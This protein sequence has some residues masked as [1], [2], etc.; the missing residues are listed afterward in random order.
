MLCCLEMA[1]PE[2]QSSR[3]GAVIKEFNRVE[4]AVSSFEDL[5]GWILLIE[6][7]QMLVF[8]FVFLELG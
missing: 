5:T 7:M 2:G 8:L 1:G 4:K 6:T 3:A